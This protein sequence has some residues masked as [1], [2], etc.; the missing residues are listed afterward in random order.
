MVLF[1]T[2]VH[3]CATTI[4]HLHAAECPLLTDAGLVN[5]TRLRSLIVTNCRNVTTVAPLLVPCVNWTPHFSIAVLTVPAL[6]SDQSASP[7]RMATTKIVSL[8]A[9]RKVPSSSTL[10]MQRLMT[11]NFA[12]PHLWFVWIFRATIPCDHWA[13]VQRSGGSSKPRTQLSLM[14]RLPPPPG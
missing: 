9:I 10:L 2:D 11:S 5:A 7:A 4:R 1:F 6:W 8:E 3:F 13:L 14:Q 12:T